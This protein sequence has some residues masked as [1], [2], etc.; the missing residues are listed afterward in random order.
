M[1]LVELNIK[2]RKGLVKVSLSRDEYEKQVS[3]ALK[4]LEPEYRGYL[5]SQEQQECQGI[6]TRTAQLQETSYSQAMAR[7][8]EIKNAGVQ[9]FYLGIVPDNEFPIIDALIQ[10]PTGRLQQRWT[11]QHAQAHRAGR[12]KEEHPRIQPSSLEDI[13]EFR[14]L[15]FDS[16]HI[17]S[18][19]RKSSAF[20]LAS[21]AFGGCSAQQAEQ[22]VIPEFERLEEK[23]SPLEPKEREYQTD[24]PE[25]NELFWHVG[26]TPDARLEWAAV[27]NK[28]LCLGAPFDRK[29]Y[30]HMKF[31]FPAII[32]PQERLSV[33]RENA[34]NMK[35]QQKMQESLAAD[36]L[37]EIPLSILRDFA[38]Q[39]QALVQ[40]SMERKMQAQSAR[41]LFYSNDIVPRSLGIT[42]GII[43]FGFYHD[44]LAQAR[45]EKLQSMP[46][47]EFRRLHH[48]SAL[49]VGVVRNRE[50]SDTEKLFRERYLERYN[51][52]YGKVK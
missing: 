25:F 48:G 35:L 21:K 3:Q 23:F 24:R 19:V 8:W 6:L 2:S 29:T 1:D 30:E 45:L 4:L 50:P 40:E 31:L 52:T 10:L 36:D 17:S 26:Y 11:M 16:N 33:L 47:D 9:P 5:S 41:A 39:Y 13:F 15:A 51:N 12:K 22:F 49:S 27:Y 28:E 37:R 34:Q 38:P 46:E 7:M 20:Y 43:E 32:A 14:T 18:E 42:G 44:S